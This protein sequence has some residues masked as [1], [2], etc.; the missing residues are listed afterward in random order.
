MT[1]TGDDITH[2]IQHIGNVPFGKEGEQTCIKNVLYVPTITNN[3][4]LVGQIVEQGMQVC[5]NNEG[6]FI[7][8]DG[9]LIP[10]G[11]REGCMFI[12]DSNEV[13]SVMYAKGLKTETSIELCHKRISHINLQ[14]LQTMQLEGVVIELPAFELKRVDQVSEACQLGKQHRLPFQKESSISKGF[15][16]VIHSDVWGPAQTSAI[17]GCRYYIT[18]TDDYSHYTWIFP[19][20]KKREVLSH[21]QKHKGE[22]EHEMGRHIRCLWSD[23]GKEYFAERKN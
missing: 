9:R 20:K 18:F 10:R 6:C 15:L 13:K 21:F 7:E 19:M 12:L 2:R 23:G 11:W 1:T 16:D 14:L 8:K 4:I 5:F 22:V 3:L 17:G